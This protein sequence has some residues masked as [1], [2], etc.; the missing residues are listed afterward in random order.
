MKIKK[1]LILFLLMIPCMVDAKSYFKFSEAKTIPSRF[2][3]EYPYYQWYIDDFNSYGYNGSSF[4][5]VTNF[6]VGGFLNESEFN[7]S[8]HN[9][10]T[11]L[12]NGRY[13]W[14]MTADGSY[15]KYLE[16]DVMK[17]PN[18]TEF[19]TGARVTEYVRSATNV[20]GL[21][22][23]A[24][25]WQF[26]EPDFVVD[27]TFDNPKIT[28]ENIVQT[29]GIV[30]YGDIIEYIV[31][32]TNNGEYPAV[33][34]A[35]EKELSSE[36][37]NNKI[38]FTGA[39]NTSTQTN[40]ANKLMSSEG[41]KFT[42]NGGQTI[43]YTFKV[44]VIGNAGDV[45]ENLVVYSI[46]GIDTKPADKHKT[47]IEKK[48]SYNE[49]AENGANV[50]LALDNSG[51]MRNPRLAALKAA[52]PIFTESL[53]GENA[54]PNNTVCAVIMP[55]SYSE[56]I[57]YK[58]TQDKAELDTYLNGK[59]TAISGCLTPY[60][61]TLDK[62]LELANQLASQYRNYGNSIVL[63]SDGLP[64]G[65]VS[66][67]AYVGSAD[68]IKANIPRVEFYTIGFN[69]TT[70]AA[71]LLKG[72]A[73]TEQHYYSADNTDL[74]QIFTQ[75]SKSISEKTKRTTNGVFQISGEIDRS[76][77]LVIEITSASGAYTK[78]E[79]SFAQAIN[80]NYLISS[81]TMYEI[82]IK[83]FKPDDKISVTYFLKV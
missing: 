67:T 28:R 4:T 5:N 74:S 45:I 8:K 71:N 42:I 18:N 37:S 30:E 27:L 36:I 64:E 44:K 62:S 31:R 26:V 13:Y 82:N 77:R 39:G 1:L 83:M 56:T 29:D 2:I 57:L 9:G 21:G 32:V 12:I 35:K 69:A 23:Y 24:N 11:Y 33:V 16:N 38:T 6:T 43:E 70:S 41:L 15:Y 58:C 7:I 3:T 72:I 10:H 17:T 19:I 59:L 46:D 61:V 51:S 63:L 75:V 80:E 66:S 34:V 50:I 40:N 14:T 52:V 78:K 76:R 47:P 25:P 73:T 60:S 54:N 20:I 53:L 49:I 65:D 81:G 55:C 22:S 68:R 79:I 48:V